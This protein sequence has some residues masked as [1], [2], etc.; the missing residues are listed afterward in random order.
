MGGVVVMMGGGAVGGVCVLLAWVVVAVVGG[1][2][3][4]CMCLS[5]LVGGGGVGWVVRGG[6]WRHRARSLCLRGLS[7]ASPS[8]CRHCTL[9][10]APSLDGAMCVQAQLTDSI[11]PKLSGHP[12]DQERPRKSKQNLQR[13]VESELAPLRG[14]MIGGYCGFDL[15]PPGQHHSIAEPWAAGAHNT[16][17]LV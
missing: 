1:G 5:L 7:L 3:V 4:R 13:V 10:K 6:G 15:L 2:W 11:I 17:F 8:T 9:Y 16:Y 12:A 14:W